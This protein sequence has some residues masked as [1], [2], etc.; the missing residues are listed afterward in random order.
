MTASV[1]LLSFGTSE[2]VSLI[3]ETTFFGKFILLMLLVLSVVSW[4]VMLEK[5][6]Q[7]ARIRS[8]HLQ[9]W[10]RLEDW[11]EGR[12]AARDLHVWAE[13]RPDLPLA[14]QLVEV[15]DLDAA[16]S[17]RRASE[18]IAYLEIERLERYLMLLATAV[19]ISPF[20]GLMGT[21]WGIMTSFWNMAAMQS[22]NL[23]VVAP[24]IAE[25]LVTTIAGLA[26][27]IPAVIFYNALVRKIDLVGNEMERLRTVLEERAGGGRGEVHP[28]ARDHARRPALHDR[29]HI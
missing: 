4:A 26:T 29:E 8:G 13:A 10:D 6:R 3:A 1:F 5:G 2:L 9:F 24:G 11:L 23:T 18:R 19:S 20:L 7:L 15:R 16:P 27:A 22:A 28:G 21:V 17:V 25:A 12:I 14:N